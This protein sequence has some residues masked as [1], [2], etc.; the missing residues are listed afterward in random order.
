MTIINHVEDRTT[1]IVCACPRCEAAVRVVIHETFDTKNR[2]LVRRVERV[3]ARPCHCRSWAPSDVA[4]FDALA[5][6]VA[7]LAR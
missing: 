2:V 7:R 4:T 3:G 1:T 5:L 6:K